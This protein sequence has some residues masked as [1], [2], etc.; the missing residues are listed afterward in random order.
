MDKSEIR[1]RCVEAAIKVAS[2]QALRTP[3]NVVDIATAFEQYIVES[4]EP[5]AA[6]DQ[7]IQRRKPGRP[8][9]SEADNLLS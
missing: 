4:S 2:V 6:V 9:K 5:V 1:M 7:E 3:K 8:R